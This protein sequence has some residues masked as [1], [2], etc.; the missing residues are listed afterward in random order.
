[1]LKIFRHR[2][3]AALRYPEFRGYIVARF[4]FIM[5]LTM[6][7]TLIS[8]QVFEITKDPFSIGLIGLVEFVPA[9]I[10]A[11]YS[12]YIIDRSD[13]KKLLHLSIAANLLLT[14]LF[15]IVSFLTTAA[16]G[17]GSIRNKVST[18][19]VIIAIITINET[20][21]PHKPY[22]IPPMAG[23]PTPAIC[24]ELLCQLMAFVIFFLGTRRL[25]SANEVGPL[26]ARAIPVQKAMV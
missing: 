25:T 4:F 24:Q 18:A 13:K 21:I 19:M 14:I 16:G 22:R 12:G 7:A 1:M 26:N 17:F 23:P 6:Q 2:S 3:F 8:W 20:V 10:M 15:N 11:L 5:V 9:V